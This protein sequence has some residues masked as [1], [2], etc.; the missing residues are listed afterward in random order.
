MYP[1]PLP[2]PGST[3]PGFTR[4]ASMR[5][6]WAAI[7]AAPAN[8]PRKPTVGADIGWPDSETWPEQ[9]EDAVMQAIKDHRKDAVT[10]LL[11]E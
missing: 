7:E 10:Y 9:I 11:S 8:S 2:W 5:S 1:V 6:T 4:R 3:C